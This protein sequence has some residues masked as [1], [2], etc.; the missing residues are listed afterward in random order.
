M[1]LIFIF[2]QAVRVGTEGAFGLVFQ[3]VICFH[4]DVPEFLKVDGLAGGLE[5]VQ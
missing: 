4:P 1:A 3:P 2:L 5:V